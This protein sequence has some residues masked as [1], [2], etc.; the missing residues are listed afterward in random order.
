MARRVFALLLVATAACGPVPTLSFAEDDGGATAVED[1]SVMQADAPG[2]DAAV[3]SSDGSTADAEGLT[4][5]SIP[6]PP[7]VTAC[8]GA[9]QCV[10]RSPA[11]LHCAVCD[12]CTK[13]GADQVCCY[14][15]DGNMSCK[16][17]IADC[18]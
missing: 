11:G 18:K 13:C 5:P 15:P 10:D 8:C 9:I 1:A 12:E 7:G 6:P 14:R 2:A 16:K 4:C 17:T 3:A